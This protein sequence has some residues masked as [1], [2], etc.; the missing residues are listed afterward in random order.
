MNAV[1][2]RNFEHSE[3]NI[4]NTKSITNEDKKIESM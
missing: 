3:Y 2:D 1:N 4:E